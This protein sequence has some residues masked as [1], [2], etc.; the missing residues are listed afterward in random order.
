M[1]STLHILMPNKCFCHSC[2]YGFLTG[3]V[4]LSKCNGRIS[5]LWIA[6]QFSCT[7]HKNKQIDTLPGVARG[8]L[9]REF[10]MTLL[11]YCLPVN[12][13]LSQPPFCFKQ[14]Q[15]DAFLS[16]MQTTVFRKKYYCN[17]TLKKNIFALLI[18]AGV[19]HGDYFCSPFCL[20]RGLCP[21]LL[22]FHSCVNMCEISLLPAGVWKGNEINS[23]SV[24]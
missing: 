3:F 4:C 15:A 11:P 10:V 12:N 13:S 18:F 21:S 2:H 24:K 14:T 16:W 17:M 5:F 19:I 1:S 9:R 20:T 22:L 23:S 7:Y 6:S 8:D